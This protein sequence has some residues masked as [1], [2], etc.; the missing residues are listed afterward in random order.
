MS[1]FLEENS[2][3]N[4][5]RSSLPSTLEANGQNISSEEGSVRENVTLGMFSVVFKINFVPVYKYQP[6]VWV[7]SGDRSHFPQPCFEMS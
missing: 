3:L 1:A 2:S 5:Q 7:G 4:G 6:L